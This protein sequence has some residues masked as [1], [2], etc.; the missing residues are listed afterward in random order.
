MK[1][2]FHAQMLT[3]MKPCAV[4]EAR[5]PLLCL[6]WKGVVWVLAPLANFGLLMAPFVLVG[7]VF[8]AMHDLELTGRKYWALAGPVFLVVVW[9]LRRLARRVWHFQRQS[10]IDVDG[11]VALI[12]VALALAVSLWLFPPR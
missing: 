3:E 10:V 9:Y 12:A 4:R 11:I 5:Y 1:F 6:V 2:R 8:K 7:T